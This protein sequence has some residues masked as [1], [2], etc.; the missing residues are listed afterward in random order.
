MLK[1]NTPLLRTG[2]LKA[3]SDGSL[4]ASTAWF[5]DPYEGDTTN[6][7]LPGDLITS[8]EIDE[9][10]FAADREKFQV[11]IH[12]IGDKANY[13]I[14]DLYKRIKQ[15]N[16][17]RDRRF[18]IEHAQHVRFEDLHLFSENNIIASVQPYH[19]I[20]DGVWAENRIGKE[21]IKYTHPYKSFLENNVT[22]CFGTDWPIAP[23][24]PLMG[25]YAAVTRRT[26]DGKNP[27]GWIPEQKISVQDAV[28]C[29]TL[30]SAYAGFSEQLTGSIEPGKYADLI[31]L[32]EDIFEIDPVKIKEVKVE[33]T[34]FGGKIV[35][36][37]IP[38]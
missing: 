3:Y 20:D 33:T 19:C 27:E 28:K 4:G 7:G 25:I 10:S 31:I 30:N 37:S 38:H 11:C 24:N 35:Y 16:P 32:S 34:I 36:G 2:S 22:V 13:Y 6:K 21:R 9:L 12:A 26:V 17:E 1:S 14:L 29:Y 8:G 15:N 23:V 5:F 18:R